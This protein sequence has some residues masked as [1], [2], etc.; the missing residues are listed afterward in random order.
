M[1]IGFVGLGKMGGNMAL[2]LTQG[3]PDGKI[4]GGHQ[5][6]G[7]AKDPNPE[8]RGVPGI[9][10][11]DSLEKMVAQL[12]PPRVVWVMVPAGD[13]TEGVIS[14]LANLLQPN[15]IIIDGGNSYYKDSVRREQGLAHRKIGF[16]DVGTSGGIWGRQEG[17]CMMIGGQQPYVHHCR[18]IFDTLAPPDGWIHAGPPGSGH[19]VKMVHNG[20][21]YGLMEA[22][23]EGFEVLHKAPFPLKLADIASVWNHGSVVRSW[24]LE[25]S[26]R[27]FKQEDD[28][29]SIEPY[30]VD[31]GEGQ[32]TVQ[33]AM[34]EAVPAPVIVAALF[35]RYASRDPEN[36]S[37]RYT[38][39]LRNQFGGHS[40][41]RVG[42]ERIAPTGEVKKG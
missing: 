11:V 4:S 28:L 31:S 27:V 32:W 22:Y 20:I 8:L 1:Q 19:F 38:A 36:F 34:E 41:K 29:H 18:P 3:S 25:L 23:A 37:A 7:F 13:A 14:N 12:A 35:A 2:R 6:V 21:E 30:V 5:V 42:E 33:A 17:Y 26:E 16:L 40:I 9:T 39:A 15:D 10:T 24:L